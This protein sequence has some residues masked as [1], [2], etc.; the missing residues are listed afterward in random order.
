MN[1]IIAWTFG[2]LVFVSGYQVFSQGKPATQP[3]YVIDIAGNLRNHRVF[4]LSEIADDVSYIRLETRPDLLIGYGSI[5]LAGKYI[6][7]GTYRKPIMLFTREG[8]YIRSI[9]SVGKGPGE[10]K[11]PSINQINPVK[12]ELFV[13]GSGNDRIF[14]YSFSGKLLQD[15]PLPYMCSDFYLFANGNLL[16]AT[17]SNEKADGFYPFVLLD[18]KGKPI[19]EIQSLEAPVGRHIAYGVRPNFEAAQNGSV[20][21][22]NFGRDVI[23]Q[24]SPAGEIRPYATLLLG[25]LK[26][27]D[28]YYYDQA[29]WVEKP[30]GYFALGFACSETGPL[31]QVSYAYELHTEIGYFDPKTTKMQFRDSTRF[32]E[33]G[34]HNDLD[35]GP[36]FGFTQFFQ[37]GNILFT[38]LMSIDIK[39]N[40]KFYAKQEALYPDK[41]KAMLEMIDSL[42]END[43][44]VIMVVRLR[45]D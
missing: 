34:F 20:I 22:N 2:L 28:E 13:L 12:E 16:L 4:K 18:P 25:R 27:P 8:K 36:A 42:D 3:P 17:P 5:K 26:T 43:N 32:G 14:K 38:S 45:K 31:L 35:G 10:Y 23:W 24:I 37:E 11:N 9:G 21:V 19:K 7:V 29:K 1:R 15:I 33:S 41:K 40:R 6:L 30:F 44:P 39:V